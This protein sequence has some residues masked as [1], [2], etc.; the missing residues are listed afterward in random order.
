MAKSIWAGLL[1]L[2]VVAIAA[3]DRKQD[4]PER[5]YQWEAKAAEGE[6]NLKMVGSG[7]EAYYGGEHTDDAGQR[8]TARFPLAAEKVC[9]AGGKPNSERTPPGETDWNHPVWKQLYFWVSKAHY[10]KYCYQSSPDGQRFAA[11]AEGR[12]SGPNID[13]IYCI[14]G[15]TETQ[16][17]RAPQPV[18]SK[19]SEVKALSDCKL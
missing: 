7:A 3:C 14:Q 17:G 16:E 13:I 6:E 1:C 10:F 15:K 11:T 2:V 9:S 8:F 5:T 18:L 19:P 4:H 12:L